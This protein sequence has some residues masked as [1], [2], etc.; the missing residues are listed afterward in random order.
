PCHGGVGG[1]GTGCE[2]VDEVEVL[3]RG[4]D[5]EVERGRDRAVVRD[6]HREGDH[7]AEYRRVGVERRGEGLRGARGEEAL[8]RAGR[9]VAGR[10]VRRA[11]RRR[12]ACIASGAV[13]GGERGQG[14]EEDGE[15]EET[16]A[17]NHETEVRLWGGATTRKQTS[18]KQASSAGVRALRCAGPRVD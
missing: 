14:R 18:Q 6:G 1:E 16:G 8:R 9:A 17:R 4:V 7:F 13:G 2:L 11:H 10:W 3:S 15:A 5:P 12:R